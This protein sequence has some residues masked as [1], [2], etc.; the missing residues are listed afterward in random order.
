[1][2]NIEYVNCIKHK[3][4]QFKLK[5]KINSINNYKYYELR[6]PFDVLEERNN[7]C[8]GRSKRLNVQLNT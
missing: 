1:M 5:I 2:K 3:F 4:Y 7:W 6:V 8:R